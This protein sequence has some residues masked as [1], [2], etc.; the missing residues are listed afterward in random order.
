MVN[1]KLTLAVVLTAIVPALLVVAKLP[2]EALVVAV[3]CGAG[4]YI[5][6]TRHG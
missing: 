5:W 4:I 2:V 3:I 6:K 1:P